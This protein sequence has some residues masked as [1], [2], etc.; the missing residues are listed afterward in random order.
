MLCGS[1]NRR[2]VW[3]RMD[4]CICMAESL[5]CPPETVTTLAI[6]YTPIQN[7]KLFKMHWFV[8]SKL[9]HKYTLLFDNNQLETLVLDDSIMDK[10][11]TVLCLS[12]K[13]QLLS[14][15]SLKEACIRE[16]RMFF[17]Y[18][19]CTSSTFPQPEIIFNT[20][21]ILLQNSQSSQSSINH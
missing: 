6:S 18:I 8:R 2:G 11:W 3:R 15:I 4:T 19:N 20:N 16:K 14:K 1:L 12:K 17:P 9:P 5:C 7:K 13:A 21:V 10:M